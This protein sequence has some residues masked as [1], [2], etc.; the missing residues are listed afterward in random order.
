METG[1][2]DPGD[3]EGSEP[4]GG[5]DQFQSLPREQD[6]QSRSA[7]KDPNLTMNIRERQPRR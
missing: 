4:R 5:A 3:A 6:G 1:S 7:D 2:D